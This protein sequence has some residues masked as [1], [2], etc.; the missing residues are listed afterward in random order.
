MDNSRID[1]LGVGFDD[2]TMEQAVSRAYEIICNEEERAEL[3]Q[4]D[5]TAS[6][7]TENLEYGERNIKKSY[8][9]TPNPEIVWLARRN[10]ELRQTLNGAGLV[11]PDGT[12]IILGARI[13]G[14][15]LRGG[16]VT[17]IDFTGTLIEKMASAGRSI[18]LLGAKPGVA[19]EAGQKLEGKYPGIIVSGS[20]DGYYTD[21]RPII[22]RIN[23][24]RPD[25]LLVC[26]GS[27]K[28]ELWMAANLDK[29]DVK[30]CIGLGG[31]LDVFAG[32]VKRAPPAFQKM[33]LEWLHRLI[34]EPRRIKRMIKLPLFVFAVIWKR[35]AGR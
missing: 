27:P 12:G 25:F 17:G 32:K 1:V 28:Q 9:V 4:H 3:M 33:G 34:R 26:L 23:S 6:E 31:A 22:E 7:Y 18:F 29:L 13:L 5:R 11:L 2:I 16:R 14:K 15:P 10:E 20:A 30:L 19:E 21:D 24:A 35:I 8:I